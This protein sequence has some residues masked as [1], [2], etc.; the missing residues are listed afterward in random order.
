MFL[1][2]VKL[3]FVLALVSGGAMCALWL[4]RKSRPHLAAKAVNRTLSVVDTLSLGPATRLTV[5]RFGDEILLL[6]LNRAGVQMLAS[7]HAQEGGND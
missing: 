6:S 5:V 4:L 1:Y 7:Q 2:I 3:L